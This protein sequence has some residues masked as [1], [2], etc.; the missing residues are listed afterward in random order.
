MVVCTLLC[1]A[2]ISLPVPVSRT[3]SRE[4]KGCDVRINS[5]AKICLVANGVCDPDSDHEC[6][7][8]R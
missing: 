7:G 4:E 6:P 1:H 8:T 3:R 5:N 2:C